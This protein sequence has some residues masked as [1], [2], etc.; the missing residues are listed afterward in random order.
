MRQEDIVLSGE[1][2]VFNI[3]ICPVCG[4]YADGDFIVNLFDHFVWESAEVIEV[5]LS[6]NGY[7]LK[8]K[9]II[10]DLELIFGHWAA[11]IVM[12]IT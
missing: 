6:V 2:I 7:Q 5:D 12:W 10:E 9:I 1:S 11:L 8:V 4:V 3:Q